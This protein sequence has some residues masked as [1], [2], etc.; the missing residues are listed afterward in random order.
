MDQALISSLARVRDVE[1]LVRL[2]RTKIGVNPTFVSDTR[3]IR[4]S[5]ETLLLEGMR[6]LD[7]DVP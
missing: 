1:S 7:E 3:I 4:D 5:V 6:R 2:R